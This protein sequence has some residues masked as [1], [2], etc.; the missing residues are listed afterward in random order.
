[1]IKKYTLSI[2]ILFVFS[3][4]II[5][6]TYDFGFERNSSVIV[7]DIQGNPISMP[8]VGGFNSVHMQQM[9]LN[10]DGVLDLLVFDI[11]GNKLSTF[12]NDN[13]ADSA[14]YTY[15]PEYAKKLPKIISWI[16]TLDYD[17]DGDMDIFTYVP[18]G[19]TV[20]L[21]ESTSSDLIFT[22]K[23]YMIKY[24]SEAGYYINIFVSAVDYPAIVDVDFDGD[25]DIVTFDILGGVLVYFKNYSTEL[26]L[27]TDSFEFKID[28]HCW[29]NFFEGENS[30]SVMLD[31]SCI[32]KTI[33][34]PLPKGEAKHTGSTVLIMDL[35]N[36]TLNDLLLGD[37][38]FFTITKLMNGG[39]LDSAHMISQD[40]IF[41][42]YDTSINL[43]SFP[44]VNNIDIDN[45]GIKDFIISPYEAA[46]YKPEALNSVHLYEN[47]GT[48]EV[49]IL[50]FRMKNFMQNR[51][52]DVGDDASPTL[53]D[54]D[55]DGLKD[56]IIGNYGEIES[57]YFDTLWYIL[58]TEKI[59]NL[60]YYKNVG[61]AANA[62]FQFMDGNW[63]N[64]DALGRV[65]LK[66]TFGDLDGDGDMDML[67]GNNKG[68]LIYKE[69]IGGAN[70]PMNFDTASIRNYQSIDVGEFSAPQLIDIDG[71]NL[72]D[73]V[74]GHRRGTIHYYQNTGTAT[75][76]IFTY[77]TDSMGYVNTST[78]WHYNNGYSVPNFFYDNT[79]TLRA[80]IGS[81]SGFVFYYK[82]IRGNELNTFGVDSNLYYTDW[83]ETLYS[84]MSFTN[85]GLNW[86][87][88]TTGFRSCPLMYDFDGDTLLDLMI[89]S[90]SGGIT[91]FKGTSGPS[92]GFDEVVFNAPQ[93]NAY[94]NPTED[95][96]NIDISDIMKIKNIELTVF[97]VAGRVISKRKYGPQGNIRIDVS[98]LK[99]G[100][101]FVK[102][103][104]TSRSGKK[105][106]KVLKLMRI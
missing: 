54:V 42:I 17:G 100:I 75:N 89:G 88:Y 19:I 37:V 82:D 29:G 103:D 11:H 68:T 9:D 22:M 105:D 95:I 79:D 47:V 24:Y 38:D 58:Q 55:G 25:F 78:Y 23:E 13:I 99:S 27:P 39:T 87:P 92:V 49:P 57:S 93:I 26:S 50:E 90:F 34:P 83:A 46:Y 65:A 20:Y 32:N 60:T 10:L 33:E 52:I 77:V 85:E 43:I 101:Y 66:P 74:I 69:N 59:S 71:D 102:L 45:N 70:Q 62:E 72:I 84:V 44:V 4:T 16:Q 97:D 28:D 15:A 80:M 7:K 1:M 18:G 41:P 8:W 12:I 30:N 73:L 76:P 98:S 36:D 5:G 51:M 61:S 53:V 63:F 21:N 67:C 104:F 94:P 31:H 96:F 35:N 40:T 91:Y 14:S 86:E 56:L 64:M 3:T 48:N 2:L 106:R 6:Q 81:A